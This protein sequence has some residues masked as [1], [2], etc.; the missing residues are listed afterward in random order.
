MGVPSDF[1]PGVA[2]GVGSF[3]IPSRKSLSMSFR[4]EGDR[5]LLFDWHPRPMPSTNVMKISERIMS[6]LGRE[7]HHAPIGRG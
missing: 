1:F 2:P 5:S 6:V 7:V 3:L 4:S